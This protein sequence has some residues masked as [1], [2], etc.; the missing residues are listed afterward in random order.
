MIK[1]TATSLVCLATFAIG[2]PAMAEEIKVDRESVMCFEHSGADEDIIVLVGE[3]YLT[4]KRNV[5]D[6]KL[7]PGQKRCLRY[8]GLRNAVATPLYMTEYQQRVESGDRIDPLRPTKCD[9]LKR[10]SAVFLRVGGDEV[11]DASCEA[12]TARSEEQ[13]RGFVATAKPFSG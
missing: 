4:G 10:D 2:A 8:D 3:K 13:I 5:R 1:T 11:S 12:D 6:L 9:R 7:E